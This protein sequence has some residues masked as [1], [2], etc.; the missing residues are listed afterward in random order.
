MKS[1]MIIL[2]MVISTCVLLF[3]NVS[4]AQFWRNWF[5]KEQHSEE[6]STPGQPVTETTQDPKQGFV[7]YE[8]GENTETASVIDSDVQ[9]V[10]DIDANA[11]QAPGV[12]ADLSTTQEPVIP[13]SAEIDTKLRAET[14]QRTQEQIDQIKKMQEINNI[15]RSIDSIKRIN[16]MNQQ[17][18]RVDEI[19]RLNMIQR[20]L[21]ALRRME[22]TKK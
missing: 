20:N 13:A 11:E 16:E 6:G 21:D 22:E 7:K 14:L 4:Y 19:N 1:K 18:R 17:H 10:D 8:I 15:Q 12:E 3:A 9:A 5:Q 2:F